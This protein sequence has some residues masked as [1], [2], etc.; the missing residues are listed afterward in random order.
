MSTTTNAQGFDLKKIAL[1]RIQNQDALT[2]VRADCVKNQDA[3]SVAFFLNGRTKQR[4]VLS[5]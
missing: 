2:V 5:C 4:H 3:H 1:K